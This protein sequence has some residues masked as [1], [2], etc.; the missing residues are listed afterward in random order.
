MR[1]K[2]PLIILIYLVSLSFLSCK[3]YRPS[4][5]FN[6]VSNNDVNYSELKYWAA[7][8]NKKDPSDETPERK[9]LPKDQKASVFF[10]HPTTYTGSRGQDQ[11]NAPID[12]RKLNKKTD[13]GTIL[14]QAS[15]W[16]HAADVYAPYYRQA[17]LHVYFTTEKQAARKALDFAY[18]DVKAAFERFIVETSDRP[19]IIASHSQGTTHAIRIIK[20]YIDGKELQ[21]RFVAAYLVG[22]PVSKKEFS[23]INPCSDSKETNCYISWRTYEENFSLP[24]FETGS[25][26]VTNPLSWKTDE[27]YVAAESNSGSL[28]LD[29]YKLKPG[30]VSAKGNKDIL[31]ANKPKFKGSVFYKSK[32][33]HPADINFYYLSIRQNAIDRVDRFL[34]QNKKVD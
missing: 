20:E 9:P 16:N 1:Q 3:T 13:A 17:H 34:I 15:A 6:P 33:F 8:P 25:V 12:N 11:W 10:I 21:K 26:L 23:T 7:H 31:W 22:M 32:N 18:G 5:D 2:H 19:I 27:E 14:F 28:L 24:M 4:G 29:F 30:I